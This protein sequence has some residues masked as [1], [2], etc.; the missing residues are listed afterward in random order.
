MTYSNCDGSFIEEHVAAA[1][2]RVAHDY[3]SFPGFY[4][5]SPET[6]AAD[7]RRQRKVDEEEDRVLRALL[8]LASRAGDVETATV[9]GER[10]N[11]RDTGDHDLDEAVRI[12]DAHGWNDL[13]MVAFKG[14][15][16]SRG[17]P[18]E[19]VLRAA[20]R[21]ELRKVVELPPVHERT[22]GVAQD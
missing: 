20:L 16:K 12:A 11:R 19:A 7:G 14:L 21:G 9:P 4:N 13:R 17:L 15:A 6:R 2:D 10:A 1:L 5:P 8:M 18:L 22:D 3:R